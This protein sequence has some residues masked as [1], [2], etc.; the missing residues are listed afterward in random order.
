MS[1]HMT[2][3]QIASAVRA[4][5][6]TPRDVVDECLRRISEQDPA[7]GAF[8]EVMAH[9]ARRAADALAQRPDLATLALA[10]VPVAVKDNIAVEGRPTWY[11]SAATPDNV[12][13]AD[14]ELVRRLRAAGAIVV[15]KTRLPELAIWGFTESARGGTRNPRDP[16]RNAGGST[17]GGAAAVAAGLVPL[18]LGSDGGGS[19]RIPAANC[20]VVGFKPGRGTVPVAG[21]LR[22]HWHGLTEFGPVAGC[23]SDVA[24][25]F[26]V[27]SG[28]SHAVAVPGHPWRVAVSL[29]SPSPIGRANTV[30]RDALTQAAKA[31]RTAGHQVRSDNPPYPPSIVNAWVRHWMAG[32]TEDVERLGLRESDL[33]PATRTILHK[34]RRLVHRGRPRPDEIDRWRRRML[35]WFSRYDVLLSPTIAHP[36]PPMGWARDRGYLRLYLNGARTVPYTQAWNLSGLPAL[37]LPIGA[38]AVQIVAPTEEAVLSMALQLEALVG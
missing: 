30:G 5:Q 27:L 31:A 34:G 21:G 10:G 11:G 1:E 32:V 13:S 26:D 3:D 25:A 20:G 28:V 6:R 18:S 4:G 9:D 8:S 2:V 16:A 33:E 17:G 37:S 22:Q 12:A 14:D 29:R 38:G 19:L 36:A 23:V 24:V 35:D 15:G 7:I